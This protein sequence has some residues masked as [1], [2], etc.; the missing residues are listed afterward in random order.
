M[1]SAVTV[2]SVNL[3]QHFYNNPDLDKIIRAVP[4][5]TPAQTEPSRAGFH[6]SRAERDN[7]TEDDLLH[8]HLCVSR[9]IEHLNHRQKSY[10]VPSKQVV[11]NIDVYVT[12]PRVDVILNASFGSLHIRCVIISPDR[13]SLVLVETTAQVNVNGFLWPSRACVPMVVFM[14]VS[15]QGL[16]T[17]TE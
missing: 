8:E 15:H 6:F 16:C 9:P 11:F 3:G 17:S 10:P 4:S 14:P 1:G 12:S 7:S 2:H 5:L 13:H